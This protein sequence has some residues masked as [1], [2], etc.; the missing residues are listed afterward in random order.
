MS[1]MPRAYE[2]STLVGTRP[3]DLDWFH[4]IVEFPI[5]PG[6]TSLQPWIIFGVRDGCAAVGINQVISVRDFPNSTKTLGNLTLIPD[7]ELFS[8][9][10]PLTQTL[11][12]FPMTLYNPK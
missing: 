2:L 10:P 4:V 12:W 7:I 5:C 11:P 6:C 3:Q 8:Y 9:D 1:I